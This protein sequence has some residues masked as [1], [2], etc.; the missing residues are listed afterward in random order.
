MDDD[1]VFR[2]NSLSRFSKKS[3][4][5]LEAH[6]HCEVP[7][8]CGGVVLQ[9]SHPDEGAPLAIDVDSPL[10]VDELHLDGQ[11]V[12]TSRV[13]VR[14]GEHLIALQLA[15]GRTPSDA[16][17]VMINVTRHAE[18]A[19]NERISAACS[20]TAA[21]RGTDAAP[22]AGWQEPAFDDRAWPLLAPAEV[23]RGSL[24]EWQRNP[25]DELMR[26]GTRPLALAR[27]ASRAWL[28][29]RFTLPEV[30]R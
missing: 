30:V 6:S 25:F 7:A 28:R 9:W 10:L 24:S 26:Q 13:R 29:A 20:G 14:P 11:R 12:K 19:A 3:R 1:E 16:P 23:E 15:V 22:V 4:L 27:R 21:W 2:L 5:V 17:W 18:P 8:G